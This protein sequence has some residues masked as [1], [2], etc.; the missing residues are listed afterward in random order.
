MLTGPSTAEMIVSFQGDQGHSQLLSEI[1]WYTF[2]KTY[3]ELSEK[4][5]S[6]FYFVAIF[7]QEL[8]MRKNVYLPCKGINIDNN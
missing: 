2:P 7:T 5:Y 6:K 1:V 8:K 4:D 3:R